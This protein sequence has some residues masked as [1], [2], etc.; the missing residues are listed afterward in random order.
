MGQDKGL[1]VNALRLG[2]AEIPCLC[3][4]CECRGRWR[5]MNIIARKGE[6]TGRS[7][8]TEVINSSFPLFPFR[9]FR[10]S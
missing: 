8:T 9:S 4:E 6:Y 7:H 10:L 1:R 2:G 3:L 5:W